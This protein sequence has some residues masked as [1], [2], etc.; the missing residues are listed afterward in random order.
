MSLL[1]AGVCL[2]MFL[3]LA[4]AL[5]RESDSRLANEMRALRHIIETDA[6]YPVALNKELLSETEESEGTF[7]ARTY[8]AGGR[9]FVLRVLDADGKVIAERSAMS[10]R[11]ARDKIPPPSPTGP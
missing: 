11:I 10:D 3:A 2:A 4:G 8:R 1:I 7:G 6:A 5:R 9:V